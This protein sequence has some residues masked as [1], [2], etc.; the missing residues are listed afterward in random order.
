MAA[1]LNTELEERQVIALEKIAT[2][3]DELVDELASGLAV[4]A[5]SVDSIEG[6]GNDKQ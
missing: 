4:L 6:G 1:S 3:L 2:L 5:D